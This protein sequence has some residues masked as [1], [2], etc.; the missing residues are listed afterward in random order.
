MD[1]IDG[2]K[3]NDDG[4]DE[5]QGIEGIEE[6]QIEDDILPIIK[7]IKNDRNRA[8]VQNIHTFIN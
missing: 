3:G 7:K 1:H 8:C 5:Q 2:D 4:T 6:Q